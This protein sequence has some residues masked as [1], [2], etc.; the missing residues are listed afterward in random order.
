MQC[1][2]QQF[3]VFIYEGQIIHCWASENPQLINLCRTSVI[4]LLRMIDF[5]PITEETIK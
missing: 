3:N 5:L 4:I 2:V 1:E